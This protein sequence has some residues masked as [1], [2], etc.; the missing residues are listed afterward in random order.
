MIFMSP[1]THRNSKSF[2]A[3]GKDEEGLNMVDDS[4]FMVG[5]ETAMRTTAPRS[6]KDPCDNYD[7]KTID[8]GSFRGRLHKEE[9]EML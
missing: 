3:F 7:N 5:Q 6:Q 9:I 4:N 2:V 8:Q 1:R